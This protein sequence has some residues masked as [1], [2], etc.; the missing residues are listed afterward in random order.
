MLCISEDIEATHVSGDVYRYVIG[1]C[2]AVGDD[3]HSDCGIMQYNKE[4]SNKS[5]CLGT[6]TNTQ[7]ARSK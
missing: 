4:D 7:L 2:I 6:L 3:K 5:H 1:I